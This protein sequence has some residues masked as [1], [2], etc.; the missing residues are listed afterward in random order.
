MNQMAAAC[1]QSLCM[2]AELEGSETIAW[3]ILQRYG[4][5][6]GRQLDREKRSLRHE[7][8]MFAIVSSRMGGGCIAVSAPDPWRRV[9]TRSSG[10]RIGTLPIKLC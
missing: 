4:V 7:R 10:Q 5:T 6:F 2:I 3:M 9:F 8:L 1:V